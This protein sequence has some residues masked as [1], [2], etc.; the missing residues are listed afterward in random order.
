MGERRGT[1]GLELWCRKMTEGYAGV[2]VDNMTTSWRNGLAFCALIHHFRPDLIE[3]EKLDKGDVYG[4]NELAFRVAE[5]QLGIPALLDP[6][7]MV[8][9]EVPDRLSILTYLS[10]F[11]QC[12][13]GQRGKELAPKRP[14]TPPE[15]PPPAGPPPTTV[16][17]TVGRARREPC[18]HCDLPV[19]IAERLKVDGRVYHRACFRCARCSHPLSLANYYQTEGGEFCCEVC[20][21]EVQPAMARPLSDEEK[22]S[23]A[24][25]DLYSSHCEAA[26]E[27]PLDDDLKRSATLTPTATARS[28]FFLSHMEAE[29]GTLA[30][31][32]KEAELKRELEE[33]ARAGE[34]ARLEDPP[35]PERAEPG[36]PEEEPDTPV[37]PA[38]EEN[39]EVNEKADPDDAPAPVEEAE[40]KD[41]SLEEEQGPVDAPFSQEE[42]EPASPPG[43]ERGDA[44]SVEGGVT[45]EVAPAPEEV[46]VTPSLVPF[47]PLELNPFGE[48][49]EERPVPAART[50]KRATLSPPT[51]SNPFEEE[52]DDEITAK[53]EAHGSS[54]SLSSRKKKPAP[55]PPPSLGGTMRSRKTKRAPLPPTVSPRRLIAAPEMSPDEFQPLEEDKS[56]AGRWKRRRAASPP[57]PV[58]P[59]RSVPPLPLPEIRRELES[60]EVQQR[61][62]ENQG[63]R[64]EQIIRERSEGG[65]PDDRAP[66]DVEDLILQLFELVNEKTELFRRQAE[67]MY[68]RRQQRLEEE[69]AEVEHHIRCLMA[70]PESSKTDYD[71][72]MEE[73]LIGRLVEIVEKRN[74]IIDC[75]ESDRQRNI[76]EDETISS[77]LSLYNAQRAAPEG[78]KK[79]KKLKKLTKLL[80]PFRHKKD[81]H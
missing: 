8:E 3:F 61:G 73:T 5:H 28:L 1:K 62:L 31:P 57:R 16:R 37:A 6:E 24:A 15:P 56:A 78:P 4:N 75:L 76:D 53:P 72:V 80:E 42:V 46:K 54:S 50:K 44:Q 52:D 68:L 47:Y 49:E 25:P 21:D 65:N 11:Y 41:T 14:A 60:I 35:A 36:R 58:P 67:L 12:F 48:E 19:F 77:Q 74:R 27:Q 69:Q 7:D 26:L 66:P 17:T 34:E 38:E 70:Q 81:K 59:K 9:Y 45:V 2:R 51:P 40:L 33:D 20:P 43:E 23:M 64:L 29:Q 10:Q 13:E 32:F 71:K 79:K 63:V 39:K 55:P 18:A 22:S 30:L